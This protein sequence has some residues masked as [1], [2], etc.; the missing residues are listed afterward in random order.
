MYTCM[1]ASGL[2]TRCPTHRSLQSALHHRH[3]HPDGTPH[4]CV[5]VC[6]Y[7]CVRARVRACVRARVRACMRAL[8]TPDGSACKEVCAARMHMDVHTVVRVG[9]CVE[10]GRRWEGRSRRA[11]CEHRGAGRVR[12]HHRL[13][14]AE[15]G[16]AKGEEAGAETGRAQRH[17]QGYV[18]M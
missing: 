3:V 7:A 2:W 12:Q 9:V 15:T 17:V 6:A 16:T 13:R 18:Q 10:P 11:V 1:H 5:R 14:E 4:A 8:T